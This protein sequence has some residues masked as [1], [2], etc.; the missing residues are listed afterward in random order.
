MA[1]TINFRES[2]HSPPHTTQA[3]PAA[4]QRRGGI[5]YQERKDSKEIG[6]L[7]NIL[8]PNLQV[9]YAKSL[10]LYRQLQDY[11][12]NIEKKLEGIVEKKENDFLCAYKA[13]MKNVQ[14]ELVEMKSKSDNINSKAI[15][16]NKIIDLSKALE[17]FENEALKL[18]DIVAKQKKESTL[19]KET[20]E[21]CQKERDFFEKQAKK[22]KK[23][24]KLYKA[25]TERAQA[26]CYE[27]INHVSGS[28]EKYKAKCE[29]A[30]SL[31]NTRRHSE[32]SVSIVNSNAH[33][34]F[35]DVQKGSQQE[36]TINESQLKGV[37]REYAD[38]VIMKNE[39]IV[40]SLNEK[41]ELRQ[42]EITK[43]KKALNEERNNKGEYEKLFVSCIKTVQ[44][45]GVSKEITGTSE[46]RRVI[47]LLV[48][49]DDFITTIYN[50]IFG[51]KGDFPSLFNK[52]YAIQKPTPPF[53]A[54]TTRKTANFRVKQGKLVVGV[55]K[56]FV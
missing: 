31:L 44:Q 22:W 25:T 54:S 30:F 43:L 18:A 8:P 32:A 20:S 47:E 34:N 5:F 41:L 42:K 7:K 15:A 23:K 24:T 33:F 46:K 1:D 39:T 2:I 52:S 35:K 36:P 16:D 12:S 50:T 4:F 40:K 45:E 17:W 48:S 53:T 29:E 13:S 55:N 28:K 27:L 3:S 56:S 10:D 49:N 38:S 11:I 21:S 51:S 14:K 6:S 26:L 19:L 37:L 9:S